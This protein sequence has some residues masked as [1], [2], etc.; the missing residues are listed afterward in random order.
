MTKTPR[1][2]N[3][4]IKSA[5][6]P[7]ITCAS[8]YYFHSECHELSSIGY[9][10]AVAVRL[11]P[12]RKGEAAQDWTAVS[13]NHQAP[14]LRL[15]RRYGPSGPHSPAQSVPEYF[16]ISLASLRRCKPSIEHCSLKCNIDSLTN[17]RFFSKTKI[18]EWHKKPTAA[19][20]WIKHKEKNHGLTHS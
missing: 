10:W 16:V 8:S 5:S 14:R 9:G 1:V 13:V 12:G 18:E 7:R 4:V 19:L 17:Q 3:R 11:V 15:G 6:S 20:L 2:N